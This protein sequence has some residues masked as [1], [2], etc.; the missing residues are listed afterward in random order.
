MLEQE[1]KSIWKSSADADKIKFDL[2]RLMI[3]LKHKMDGLNKGIQN[4]DKREI[5]ASIFGMLLF[6][7][8]ATQIPFPITKAACIMTIG[9][10][11]YVIYRLRNAQKHKVTE[12]LSLS[13]KEQLVNQKKYMT[14]QGQLLDSVLYWYVLPPFILN[15]VFIMGLGDAAAYDWTPR[16][17]N[18][19]PETMNDKLRML[20]F[21]ALFNGF[22]V[23]LN[24]RAVKKQ[25]KP[26]I[27]EIER[28]QLQL[29]NA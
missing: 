13:F 25:I 20:G 16:F 11:G 23:W 7:Y 2:S 10:F 29:E 12:D 27:Q 19:L 8:M 4:R 9:W 1:L 28:V 14:H 3:D 15:V 26:A 24:K 18:I 5:A 21:I 17:E 6:G 22:V